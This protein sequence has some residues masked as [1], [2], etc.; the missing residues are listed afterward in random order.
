MKRLFQVRNYNI[1][2]FHTVCLAW[3]SVYPSFFFHKSQLNFKKHSSY[4]EEG[5]Q[6]AKEVL[7]GAKSVT[8]LTGAGIS[9]E[10]GIPTFRSGEGL[11]KKYRPQD[12][13][14]P[15]AF[16]RDPEFVWGWYNE[17]RETISQ[18][19]PN[20]GH[21]ALVQLERIKPKFTLITQ[22]IDDLHKVA[23]SI[24]R[25]RASRQYLAGKVHK[26]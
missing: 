12:I 14:T 26:M 16:W 15:E 19:E 7:R 18:A 10:S 20:P 2:S 22:N 24:K 8:V 6:R 9:A 5:I 23:G 21:Y 13:A 17:R 1:I 3:L 25:G 11:W 4:M